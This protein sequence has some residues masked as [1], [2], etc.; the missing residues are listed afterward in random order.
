MVSQKTTAALEILEEGIWESKHPTGMFFA[1]P[2]QIDRVWDILE[3]VEADAPELQ[4]EIV[5]NISSFSNVVPAVVTILANDGRPSGK[6]KTQGERH[7]TFP[8]F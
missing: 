1:A 3:M 8:P 5:D 6:D 7:Q 2:R 4:Q